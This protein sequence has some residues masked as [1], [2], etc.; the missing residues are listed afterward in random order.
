MSTI[1]P[2]PS[3][4]QKLAASEKSRQQQEIKTVPT[5]AGSLKFR[6]YDEVTGLPIGDGPI[7]VSVADATPKNMEKLI[8]QLRGHVSVFYVL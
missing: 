6:I 1:L 4:R 3:K 2:P 5:D 8:N 7:M